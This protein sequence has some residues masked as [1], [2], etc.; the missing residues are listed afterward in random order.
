MGYLI[1]PSHLIEKCRRLKWFSDLYTPSLDQLTLTRFIDEGYLER[2]ITKM[3]KIYKKRRNFLIHCLKTTFSNKVNI[4]GYITG[5]HLIVE[6]KDSH[7]LKELLEEIEKFG[8]KIYPV[9]NHTIEKGKHPNRII[10]GFGHQKM[11]K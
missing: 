1:L 6:W 3:K 5:L 10:L 9:E 8:V 7:F 2:H 4:F 11:K